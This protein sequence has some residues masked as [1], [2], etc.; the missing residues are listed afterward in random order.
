V[1]STITVVQFV[2]A[3]PERV[4][5]TLTEPALIAR[6]WAPGNISDQVGH[7][8]ELEMPGWGAQ[9]C[10]VIES[11]PFTK[12][13]YT[14]TENWTLTWTLVEEG[15]GT[16]LILEHSG[17]DPNDKRSVDAFTRMGPGWRDKILPTLAEVART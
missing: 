11:S 3:S 1:S 10:E 6:W 7:R 5:R 8:F 14:F 2:A 9:P 17:F 16:R 15:T 12:F 13:V 4:W